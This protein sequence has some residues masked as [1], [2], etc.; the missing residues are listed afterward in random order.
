MRDPLERNARQP[1][2]R[3][4]H[5]VPRSRTESA[6]KEAQNLSGAPSR[7]V[8]RRRDYKEEKARAIDCAFECIRQIPGA[9]RVQIE[10]NRRVTA[11]RIPEG[12]P[13]LIA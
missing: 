8:R 2:L 7:L 4:E 1:I 5:V 13:K 11:K 10:E 3:K 12:Y 9:G 6:F